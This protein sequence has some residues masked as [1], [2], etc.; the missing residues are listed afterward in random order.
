MSP[1]SSRKTQAEPA[2][3]TL[4]IL[5]DDGK[6]QKASDSKEASADSEQNT[7]LYVM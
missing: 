7:F 4:F 3:E 5:S 6:V 2:P 1:S